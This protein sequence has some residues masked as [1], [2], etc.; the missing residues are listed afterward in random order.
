MI[1]KYGKWFHDAVIAEIISVDNKCIINTDIETEEVAEGTLI[2]TNYDMS[3][4]QAILEKLALHD[5]DAA[6]AE[7]NAKQNRKANAEPAIRNIPGWATWTAQ[8]A[9]DYI[10]A[11]VTDLASAKKVMKAQAKMICYLRDH[12]GIV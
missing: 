9:E 11:D 1:K 7:W 8:E 12:A 3:N 5:A 6:L 2:I 4:K 10:E